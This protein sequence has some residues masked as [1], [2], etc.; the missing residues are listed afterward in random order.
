M[1]NVSLHDA[2]TGVTRLICKR[3]STLPK[4]MCLPGHVKCNDA[5]CILEHPRVMDSKIVCKE[6]MKT[7]VSPYATYVGDQCLPLAF[8]W[9]FA[10]NPNVYVICFF[11]KV[12]WVGALLYLNVV[13]VIEIASVEMMKMDAQIMIHL[14]TWS[15]P[16]INY[17]L[18][19]TWYENIM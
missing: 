5:T 8:V 3:S 18:W 19:S 15:Q 10:I 9:M 13:T 12:A 2:K 6:R 16:F 14:A 11:T 17:K 7:I 1:T 4:E